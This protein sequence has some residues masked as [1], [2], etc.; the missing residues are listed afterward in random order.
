MA[1]ETTPVQAPADTAP[2]GDG[3]G[4]DEGTATA[5]ATPTEPTDGQHDDDDAGAGSKSAVLA[6]L[7]AER[8]KRQAAEAKLAEVVKQ[9]E[10]DDE[11]RQRE[12]AERETQIVT[13]AQAPAIYALRA[14]AIETAAVNAGF[15]DPG[16]AAMMLRDELDQI[17]VDLESATPD[18]DK[19]GELI[20]ALATR[21]PHL[22]T[23]AQRP[24][25]DR[26]GSDIQQPAAAGVSTTDN[27]NDRFMA[28]VRAKL[29][30]SG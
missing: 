27:V 18:R 10:T 15:I 12:A 22:V 28:A 9:H 23:P 30:A 8:D 14:A 21:K 1:T 7:A 2:P 13:E 3:D 6:D 29:A 19:I 11:R 4:T 17:G 25:T 24:G 5:G 16:D 26:G 20:T